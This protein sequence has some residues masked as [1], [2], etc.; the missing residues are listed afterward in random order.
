MEIYVNT[1]GWEMKSCAEAE[2]QETRELLA[3]LCQALE[4]DELERRQRGSGLPDNWPNLII[5]I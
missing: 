1:A 5:R 2:E 3:K 4:Q